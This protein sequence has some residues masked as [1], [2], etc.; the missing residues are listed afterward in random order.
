LLIFGIMSIG[1]SF[2]IVGNV[3]LMSMFYVIILFLYYVVT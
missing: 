2:G 3:I 1:N